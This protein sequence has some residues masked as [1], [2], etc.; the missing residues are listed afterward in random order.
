MKAL[1][2]YFSLTGRTKLVAE[3]IAAELGKYEVKVEAITYNKTQK[4]WMDDFK[5]TMAGDLSNFQYNESIFD[6]SPYDLICIGVPTNGLRPAYIFDAYIQK[7][8]DFDGKRV[9]VF[10]TCRL[11]AG[12]TLGN[13][14]REIE[15]KGGKV[16]DQKCFKGLFKLTD[17]KARKFGKILNQ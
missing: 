14:K 4:E 3:A 6:P 5:Q 13:M 7:A 9:V 10:N 2:I 16:T 11:I 1:I 12:K 8:R 15:K 17:E